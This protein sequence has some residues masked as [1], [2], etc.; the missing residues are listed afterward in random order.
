MS[1][2]ILIAGIGNVFKGDDAF[3][4]EVVKRLAGRN[5]PV[6]ADVVDFGINGID[7]I[8]ALVDRYDSALL[9]DTTQR[10]GVPGTL[11]VI[12]PEVPTDAVADPSDLMLTP[13]ELDP[14][15]VLRMVR[16]MD[17]R[18]R[19]IVLLGCEPADFGDEWEGKMGL[20]EP[21]AAAVEDAIGLI[22]LRIEEWF[23]HEAETR[24]ETFRQQPVEPAR[25]IEPAQRWAGG[26]A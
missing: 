1:C 18:C 6:Q 11:Y 22:E 14:V 5:L 17:G 24:A 2:N 20:T 23:A 9:I 16:A 12:E 21:V 25:L 4:V 10:G 13:H 3:G 7:L 8:Y 26:A 15:K 19:K